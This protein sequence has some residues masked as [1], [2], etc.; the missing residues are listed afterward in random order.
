MDPISI[1][2][3]GASLLGGIFGNRKKTQTSTTTP[4]MAPEYGPLQSVLINNAMSRLSSPSS[5]PAGYETGGTKAINDTFDVG[6]QSLENTLSARGLSRSPVAAT[7]L[8]RL[9]GSRLSSIAQFRNNIP[10]LNRQMQ[11]ED[12]GFASNLLSMG[13]GT[14]STGTTP[15]NMVGGGISDVASMLGFLYGGG[16]LGQQ[17][18]QQGGTPPY[19]SQPYS[20]YI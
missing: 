8:S 9:Q 5:L 13:R 17:P 14:T 19:G 6:Q 15:S 7:P 12:M 16:R 20:P 1:G 2:L 4:T 10:V 11:N 18:G 3:L